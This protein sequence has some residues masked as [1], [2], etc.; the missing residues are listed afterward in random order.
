MLCEL[1]NYDMNK[2]EFD[3]IY[4]IIKDKIVLIPK[5]KAKAKAKVEGST[6]TVASTM[7]NVELA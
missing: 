1:I 3:R 2:K 4:T 5:V 6:I 7:R